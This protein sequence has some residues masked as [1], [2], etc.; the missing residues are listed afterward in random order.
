MPVLTVPVG[1]LA[2][3]IKNGVTGVV[4]KERSAEAVASAIERIAEDRSLL[5]KL[6]NGVVRERQQRSM[7]KF[8]NALRQVALRDV[9]TS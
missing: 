6:K 9:K 4:T 7:Q 2:E 1:G 5:K 3:Q 8:L